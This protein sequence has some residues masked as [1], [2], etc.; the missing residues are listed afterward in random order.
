MK[1]IIVVCITLLFG[2]SAF[3][4]KAKRIEI[5]K[6]DVYCKIVD[7]SVKRN[8]SPHLVF[9]DISQTDKP[10]WR[11]FASE[12]TLEK[13]RENAETY[14]ITYSWQK[15]GKVVMSNFTLF[16]GSGDWVQYAFTIISA[17]TVR[18]PKLNRNCGLFTVT[19][20]SRRISISTE[21]ANF[22]K[23]LWNIL[24]W[25]LKSR[26]KRM[27]NLLTHTWIFWNKLIITKRPTNCLLLTSW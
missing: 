25:R 2:F 7:A 18:L 13:F 5:K 10:K 3:A 8:K 24:I 16:S 4:Q 9:A 20:L 19:W 15:N 26:Q 22:W 11:K 21:K 27:M 14:T 23:R 17:K 12:K 6:I 1:K